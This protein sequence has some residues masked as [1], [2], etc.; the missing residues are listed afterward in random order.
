[1]ARIVLGILGILAAVGLIVVGA[2]L[3]AADQGLGAVDAAAEGRTPGTAR[4]D[5]ED[6]DY[7]VSLG[8]RAREGVQHDA[9]CT[10]TRADGSTV[11]L[12]GDRGGV[13]INNKTIGEFAGVAGPTAV[14]CAIDERAF[15]RTS[16]RFY[17]AAQRE[18]LRT[19][20]FVVLGA[21]IV[22]LLGAVALLLMGVRSRQ[23]A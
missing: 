17:V 5:A 4:F 3:L 23:H 16:V 12:R 11:R 20:G 13:S 1:L 9:R 14:E 8:S 19:L 2:L 22:V 18:W 21:G 10:V 15:N 7:T 6:R